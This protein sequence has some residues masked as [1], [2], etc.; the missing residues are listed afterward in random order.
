M[1]KNL[2]NNSRRD[3]TLGIDT[4]LMTK[5]LNN[6][7]EIITHWNLCHN[8]IN[9]GGWGGEVR[10]NS[11][12]APLWPPSDYV[13]YQLSPFNFSSLHNRHECIL[14]THCS[15]AVTIWRFREDTFSCVLLCIE[16]T[17]VMFLYSAVYYIVHAYNSHICYYLYF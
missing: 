8:F 16:R 9:L 13:V 12:A 17:L 5:L 7:A 2:W 6:S 4:L 11:H 10:H 14:A 1:F 15:L 3:L